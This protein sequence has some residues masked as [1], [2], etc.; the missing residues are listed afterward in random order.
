MSS[1]SKEPLYA[2]VDFETSPRTWSNLKG[3]GLHFREI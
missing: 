3:Y 1:M 2:K